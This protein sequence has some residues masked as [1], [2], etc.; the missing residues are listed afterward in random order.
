MIVVLLHDGEQFF[1][2]LAK[3]GKKYWTVVRFKD[4]AA[5][6]TVKIANAAT[7]NNWYPKEGYDIKKAARKFKRKGVNNMTKAAR[8]IIEEALS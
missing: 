2:G 6:G 8:K 5:V 7:R 1:T 3:A 4:G